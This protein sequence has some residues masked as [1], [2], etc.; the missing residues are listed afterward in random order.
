MPEALPNILVVDD[1]PDNRDLISRRLLRYGYTVQ[2]VDDG[3]AALEAIKSGRFDAVLLDVMM[4]GIDGFEV[5]RRIRTTTSKTDLPVIIVTAKHDSDSVVTAL[6][7]GANDYT[8]KPINFKIL[9]ARL[10]NQVALKR[11]EDGLKALNESLEITVLKRTTDLVETNEKLTEVIQ[12]RTR[13]ADELEKKERQLQ[14]LI[15]CVPDGVITITEDRLISGFS[16]AA[17]KMFGYNEQEILGQPV[18]ALIA[19]DDCEGYAQ[20]LEHFLSKPQTA[21]PITIAPYDLLAMKSDGRT[22]P[23]DISLGDLG[24]GRDSRLVLVVRDITERKRSEAELREAHQRTRLLLASVADGVV[25]LDEEGETTFMNSAALDI[26]KLKVDAS[27]GKPFRNFIKPTNIDHDSHGDAGA[28]IEDAFRSGGRSSRQR[29]QFL[30]SGGTPID[31]EFVAAPLNQGNALV[32]AVIAFNDVTT[33]LKTEAQLRQ[34][35][36]MEAIGR[37]TGGVAHDFNNVLTI[38]IGNLQLLER[39]LSSDENSLSR[40]ERIL[41]AA[42]SAG[43]LTKRLLGLSRQ[44]VIETKAVDVNEIVTRM[45]ALLERSLGPNIKIETAL[46]ADL[47]PALTDPSEFENALLNLCVNARDAMPD[48]GTLIIETKLNDHMVSS[49]ESGDIPSGQFIELAVTDN[50]CGMDAE[51]RE[52][53]FEPFF[54]TKAPGKGTG[55]GLASTFGFVKQSGG[56]MTVY[57]ELGQGTTFRLYFPLA[58]KNAPVETGSLT[59]VETQSSE[60]L[61]VLVVD[62][63][64]G[65]REFAVAALQEMGCITLEAANAEAALEI[66]AKRPGIDV[67]LSDIIMPGSMDGVALAHH[68]RAQRKDLGIMLV[69]GFTEHRIK[70]NNDLPEGCVFLP[71]PYRFEDIAKHLPQVSGG[72]ARATAR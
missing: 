12:E 34:A 32:G 37:L 52:M 67:V 36:K 42:N 26:L 39:R 45:T 33:Q 41:A 50:G 6:E 46:A 15:D 1:N 56:H 8:S 59:P 68:L 2:T 44:E 70:N 10:E 38:I 58:D 63:E 35:V 28:L 25:G 47:V 11:A 18:T 17:Q 13:A 19:P 21:Q 14:G 40:I 7:T 29:A 60:G 72:V 20:H 65:V 3:W 31:V 30:D 23:I 24:S 27:V 57:S 71:K 48:G 69:S 53:I 43:D 54:T 55:L 61:T 5:L 9:R 16:P 66:F 4:P 64:P 49:H 22:L 51:T 62:D